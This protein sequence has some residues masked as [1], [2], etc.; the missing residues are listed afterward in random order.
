MIKYSG[1]WGLYVHV[2]LW[3]PLVMGIKRD[4]NDMLCQLDLLCSR[5]E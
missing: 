2:S 3:V 5:Q 1:L 4:F